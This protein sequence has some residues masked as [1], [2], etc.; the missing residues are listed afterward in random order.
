MAMESSA[1]RS[2]RFEGF[3]LDL[4]R[5]SLRSKDREI[6]LRPKSFS[7]L[8]Y[9]AANPG[10]IVSKQELDD[11][12]WP[13]VAVTDASLA[14][15]IREL[16]EKLEDASRTLIKTIH[17]RGYMLDTEV[18]EE[19]EEG[20]TSTASAILVSALDCRVKAEDPPDNPTLGEKTTTDGPFRVTETE[21]ASKMPAAAGAGALGNNHFRRLSDD[22]SQPGL[23]LRARWSSIVPLAAFTLVVLSFAASWFW[24]YS[25]LDASSS[26]HIG[27]A[28]TMFRDCGECPE[29]V[30]L[31]AGNID[32]NLR[33]KGEEATSGIKVIAL[34]RFE[35][36]V[37]QFA[38]FVDQS[39]F[40][41]GTKCEIVTGSGKTVSL[42]TI[43]EAS[44]RQQ[45]NKAITNSHPASCVSW[46]DAKA[47]AAWLASKTGKP[48]RLLTGVEW[49]YAARAG[50]T[51]PYSF[52][53]GVTRLCDYARFAD[54]DS[55]FPWASGC[56][57]TYLERGSLPVG[58]LKPNPWGL[59]DVHGNVWEWV[60]DCISS[61][62]AVLRVMDA[63][64]FSADDCKI[65]VI[66]GGGWAANARRVEAG[67]YLDA[68]THTRSQAVGFRVGLTID[69]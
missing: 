33:S 56:H 9:L 32:K 25:V 17:R 47:Y 21:T 67:F 2:F 37:E 50:T 26:K 64:S 5:S 62:P 22:Q 35:I 8:Y 15:C 39:N 40:E 48:Y 34:G 7:V 28:L 51:E 60:Q 20:T 59:F 53:G 43:S 23:T 10:R 41:V 38:A 29:M 68:Q 27:R 19:V 24:G 65:S 55:Q 42:K 49:E 66:R 52:K 69:R 36:T 63:K 11:A 3:C 46:H 13:N 45:P 1:K 54:L 16:R 12:I 58:S 4:E 57:S 44:F 6:V 61:D 18:T 14:Q 31:P 30:V